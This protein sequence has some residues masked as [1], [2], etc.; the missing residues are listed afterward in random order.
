M[1]KNYLTVAARALRRHPGYAVINVFGLALAL[2]CGLLLVLFVQDEVAYDRFHEQGDRIYRVVSDIK[3]SADDE[4]GKMGT[5]G[6]PYGRILEADY[7][8]VEDVVYLHAFPTFPLVHNGERLYE[9]MLYADEGFFGMFSFPLIEGSPETALTE[10]YSVVL[11]EDLA[12]R[13]FGEDAALGKQVTF[14][15]TLHFTVT[16]VAHVPEHSHLQ[17]DVMASA[18]TIRSLWG[19]AGYNEAFDYGWLNVNVINYLLLREGVDAA[20]F[21]QKVRQ[22]PMEHYAEGLNGMGTTYWINLQPLQDIYLRANG[23]WSRLGPQGDI[24]TIWLLAAI[25]GFILL[26]AA[27]NFINL[28]TARS[29]MRAKEVGVRKVVGS[30]RGQLVGQFL[31]ESLMT[32]GMAL[33]LSFALVGL[34]LP[35][36]NSLIG[37]S[38]GPADFLTLPLVLTMAGISGVLGML[39]GLYPAFVLSAFRPVEVLKGR[40]SSSRRG[41]RLRQGL[42]VFQFAISCILIVATLA[43][44]RQVDF[45]QAQEL[46]FT[47][48]QVVVLDARR[49]PSSERAARTD[50]LKQALVAHPGIH[51]ASATFTVPGRSAWG[52]IVAFPEGWAEGESLLLEYASVDHDYLETLG[53]TLVAGRDFDVERTTDINEA[54]LIN[55]AMVEAGGWASPDDAVGKHITLPGAQKR[56]A[57]VVG[58]VQNYHHHGL[59]EEIRPMVF[60]INPT[61]QGLVAMR[62][63]PEQTTQVLR[64]L[65]ATWAQFFSGYPMDYFFLDDNFARQYEAEQRLARTFGTFSLLAILIA[66]LGL[67]G[68]AAYATMLRTKEIGVRKVLGA[69]VPN[70][71]GLLSRDFLTLVLVGFALAVPVAYLLLSEWLESFA[72]A[73]DLGVGL[74]V[75]AGGLAVLIAF[76][77]VSYQSIRAAL[78]DP[79]KSLRYE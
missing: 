63:A 57:E 51:Q 11:S 58:V 27:T 12:G 21:T 4:F 66:C 75:L 55:E 76:A 31:A 14:A 6:W 22:L 42:V 35:L 2:A 13:M 18:S 46:G 16:G 56:E 78:T 68:L 36:F 67:L 74:F 9:N 60:G 53:L 39:A 26:I 24:R 15:D 70:I 50:V 45:M 25:A 19:E 7:P 65:D 61:R 20:A 17:F 72:Y 32:S 64:H 38:Y 33:L 37:K 79:V 49:A 29:T 41:R 3:Q 71:V 44:V 54:L 28:A 10:P 43:V 1:L 30:G 47:Q 69:S 34:L 40:F 8:E 23:Y 59:Q 5:I 52:S 48:E 62:V 73:M 77:T